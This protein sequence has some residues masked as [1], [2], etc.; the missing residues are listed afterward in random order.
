MDYVNRYPSVLQTMSYNFSGTKNTDEMY[1]GVVKSTGIFPKNPAQHA[2]DLQML[3]QST[4]FSSV[5]VNPETGQQKLVNV[6][7]WTVHPMKAPPMRRYS[8]I[9]LSTIYRESSMLRL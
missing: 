5:F 9:G 8:F 2:C 7:V 3:E 6:F 4:D 1:A